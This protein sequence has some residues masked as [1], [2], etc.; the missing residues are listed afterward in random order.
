MCLAHRLCEFHNLTLKWLLLS[1]LTF[2]L[3]FSEKP[4]LCKNVEQVVQALQHATA[5]TYTN[6]SQ[7][8]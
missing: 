3:S 2:Y 1:T 8:F 7:N 5:K 6:L 4:L